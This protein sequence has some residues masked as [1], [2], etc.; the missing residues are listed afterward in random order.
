ML[1]VKQLVVRY[2]R[3]TA[4][5]QVSLHVEAG[6]IVSVVGQNGAGKSSL[7]NAIAGAVGA[8][9]GEVVLEGTR[10]TGLS[11]EAIARRGVALVPEARHIF[12]R[13]TV[14]ENLKLATSARR[15]RDGFHEQL[16]EIFTMFPVLKKTFKA[17]A[18][19]LSGGEQQQ[20]AIARAL[21]ARPKV[22]L[23]DEPSLGLAPLLVDLVF[24]SLLELNRRGVTILL[25]EQFAKRAR[26]I[27]T[28]TYI[29]RSGRVALTVTG[30]I[31]EQA[32]QAAY[33]GIQEEA[34]T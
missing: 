31:E 8:T 5:Q 14:E 32:L 7:L 15:G 6:E 4:L 12:A 13:L 24:Q 22:L 18:G 26:E 19:K 21:V 23:L 29:L 10:L 28:R 34:T 16:D 1:E 27:S 2:G 17:S 3:I 25:V 33:F 20:L 11:P 9:A 30:T